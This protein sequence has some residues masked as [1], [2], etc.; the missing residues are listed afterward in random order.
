MVFN[1]HVCS[2]LHIAYQNYLLADIPDWKHRGLWTQQMKTE[3]TSSPLTIF[4]PF[5]SI[6][7]LPISVDGIMSY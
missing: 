6:P 3:L 4:P 5:S 7:L 1:E 2:F